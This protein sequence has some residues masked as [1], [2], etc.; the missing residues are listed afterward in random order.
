MAS[1]LSA[2]RRE[3]IAALVAEV[4]HARVQDL[5]RD[6]GVS[7]VSI[8]TDLAVLDR[9]GRLRRVHGGAVAVPGPE[10]EDPVESTMVRDARAKRAIGARA[11][12]LIPSGASVALDVGSTCQA[13]A[14]ALVARRD[15]TELV[16][17]TNGLSIALALEPAMPRFTVVLTGGTL[18]PLQHSL[19]APLAANTVSG[20]HV[21]I[22]VIGCN[23][24][25]PDGAVTNLNLPE[26]EVKRA[27]LAA[28]D[29]AVL[30]AETAKFGQRHL[31]GIGRLADFADV[32]TAGTP[33]PRFQT[34]VAH[35]GAAYHYAGI[36]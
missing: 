20:L 4:G 36:G 5:A 11:A 17:L 9:T 18:R 12:A 22:A 35:A 19:V 15:L 34:A 14:H 26:A 28:C 23:G 24:I 7:E 30:V 33:S 16:V 21:D 29:R 25:A 1:D 32:V 2:A 31:G 10:R 3:E 27:F 8:R 6:F 13:V